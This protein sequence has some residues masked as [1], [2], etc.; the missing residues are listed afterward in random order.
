MRDNSPPDA[1]LLSG[2]GSSPGFAENK[3]ESAS[4]PLEDMFLSLNS[5]WKLPPLIPTSFNSTSKI[6]HN[7][8]DDCFLF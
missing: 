8:F 3:N 2:F 6:S 4:M 7:L 5:I 1:T